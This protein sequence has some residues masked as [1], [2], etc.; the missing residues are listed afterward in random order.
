MLPASLSLD[1]VDLTVSNLDR[2]IAFYETSLGFK[3]HRRDGLTAHLGAGG[4]DLVVL[5]EVAGAR[6]HP[7][8]T[9]LYHFAILVP[10]RVELAQVLKRLTD[11]QTPVEGFADHLVSEAIYLPDPDGNGI[12]MYRDRPKSDWYDAQGKFKMGTE[13]LDLDGILGELQGRSDNWAGLDSS[14]VLGHMHLHV[15]NIPEAGKF[16]NDVLGFDLMASLRSALFIS[17]GGYHHHL[18]LNIWNGAGAPPPPPNSVGLRHFTVRLPGAGEADKLLGRL[19]DANVPVEKT[20]AGW[21]FQDPSQNGIV[22]Q[23]AGN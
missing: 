16:Y 7:R 13:P 19:S 9:G 8:T 15:R 17:A 4:P 21:Y 14:T 18:G 6:R 20:Q 1:S 3:M 12:E 2:S 23:A 11:T 10:S 22:I 5:T